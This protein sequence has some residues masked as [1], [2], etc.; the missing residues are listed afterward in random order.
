[1]AG[2][3]ELERGRMNQRRRD[4]GKSRS[5]KREEIVRRRREE[6]R[7]PGIKGEKEKQT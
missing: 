3:K 5:E 7:R 4:R 1:M 2:E 6:S